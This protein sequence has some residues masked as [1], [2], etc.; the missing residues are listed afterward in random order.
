MQLKD[1]RFSNLLLTK[2]VHNTGYRLSKEDHSI[3]FMLETFEDYAQRVLIYV[4]FR[5]E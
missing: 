5:N 3:A 1:M 4:K 2:P